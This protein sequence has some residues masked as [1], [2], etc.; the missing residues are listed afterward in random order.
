VLAETLAVAVTQ[1]GLAV[2]RRW[3]HQALGIPQPQP[4]EAVLTGRSGT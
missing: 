3:V 4:D 1:L 2:P